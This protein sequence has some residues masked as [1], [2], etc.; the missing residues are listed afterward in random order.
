MASVAF[1]FA[2]VRDGC[3]G[4]AQ[5]TSPQELPLAAVGDAGA[6]VAR[7]SA[8]VGDAGAPL[9]RRSATVARRCAIAT[10]RQA[11]AVFALARTGE[12]DGP[13]DVCSATVGVRFASVAVVRASAGR[14]ARRVAAVIV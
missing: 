5:G 8:R 6:S 3:A 14:G 9:A 7:R 2:T 13:Y 10:G 12:A 1:A 4:Y 11:T